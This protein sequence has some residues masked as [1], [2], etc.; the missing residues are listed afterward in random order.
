MCSSLVERRFAGLVDSLTYILIFPTARAYHLS[1]N[2]CRQIEL[3][4]RTFRD[5]RKSMRTTTP[6]SGKQLC[7]CYGCS[8]AKCPCALYFLFRKRDQGNKSSCSIHARNTVATRD[9]QSSGDGRLTR[10]PII[11]WKQDLQ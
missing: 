9:Q 4:Q 11:A 3:G 5:G 10:C 2:L 7:E 1:A 6:G 8:R